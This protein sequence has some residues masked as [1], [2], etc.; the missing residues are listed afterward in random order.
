MMFRDKWTCKWDEQNSD[1]KLL[2]IYEEVRRTQT[3]IFVLG[4]LVILG[5]ILQA[6]E[7]LLLSGPKTP[8][9]GGAAS[10]QE[11]GDTLAQYVQQA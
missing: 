4:A 7:K 6:I 1:K 9:M 8:D 11:V 10:T 2:S 3:Q 5:L